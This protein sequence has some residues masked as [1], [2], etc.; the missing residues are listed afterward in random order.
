MKNSICKRAISI[1]LV[2]A[3]ISGVFSSVSP[4]QAAQ[5][6][7]SLSQAKSMA[8]A[9]S[10]SYR[11]IKSKI[12]LKEVSYKQAVKSIQLKIKNKTTFRWSPLLSF[13][14]PED[15]N[16]EDE[17]SMVYKP[18]QI[19]NEITQ[20]KHDLID[21][22]FSVYES[23]EQ[24]F[25]K[26]YTYQ[27]MVL[28]EEE[29]LEEL[30][31]TLEKNKGRLLLGLAT[32]S[33]VETIE[34]SI[35]TAEQKLSQDNKSFLNEKEKLSDLINLDITT[36][37]SF[38]NPYISS[39]IP[40]SELDNLV[41]YTLA[42]DQSYYEAKMTT[43]L[44]L[45]QLDANYSLI[46]EQYGSKISLISSYVQQVKNGQKIDSNAFKVSYDKFLVKIDEP[47]QGNWRILFIKIPK[48]WL[49][50]DIDGVRYIEDE[51]YALYENALEYQDVLA[52]QEALAKE[53]ETQVRDTYE[54][55]VTAR[56]SYLNL[57]KQVEEA[58]E[59]LLKD[60]ILNTLGELSFEE[61][62]DSQSQYEELQMEALSALELYDSLLF[63]FDRLTCGAV[64]KYF[65]DSNISLGGGTGG[66]SYIVDEETIEGAKYYI[67]SIV[68][69]NMFEVGIY[70]PD[71]FE[72]DV[73]HYELWVD[74]Y[75]IGERTAIDQTI[76]HLTLSLTGNEKVYIRLYND[77]TFVDDCEID[78]TAYQGPL[79]ISGYVVTKAEDADRRTIGSYEVKNNEKIGIVEITVT[80]DN[81]EGIQY[82]SIQNEDGTN[83]LSE[84]KRM[85]HEA[86]KYL[87]FLSGDM[88]SLKILCYDEEENEI[89]TAYFDS[90]KY[91]IY[92][93]E[94]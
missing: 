72:T 33:D 26:V 32:A 66:S 92:V 43:Q 18:A 17:S 21:E 67:Q 2:I 93:I 25:L 44:S 41:E 70:L 34:K 9:N 78:A 14:F 65:S 60:Q 12:S 62:T 5:Y 75:Q 29:Q 42:N 85:I 27:E 38:T 8:L 84:E 52:E 71:D 24:I 58:K 13:S 57:E 30:K 22:V 73:T 40:R 37:Y 83:L 61:Y 76:R 39:E 47:W 59:Q 4:I 77:D 48:E 88:D 80:L 87:D 90:Q 19:Q 11:S 10:D 1:L 82:Y 49:K 68:E 51:P 20:L 64:S 7:L 36:R 15:L 54:S 86:F 79:D 46:K 3:V 55:V 28:F 91:E 53:L 74:S 45:L 6:T 69:D 23:T 89:Y 35:E 94:E 63:S 31:K 16:F 56:T 81:V 50:G